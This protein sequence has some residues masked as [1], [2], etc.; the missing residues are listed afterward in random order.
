MLKVK[1]NK[2]LI[3]SAVGD[4]SLHENWIDGNFDTCLIYY[5]D[6]EPPINS[7][8]SIEDKGPKYHLIK[9]AIEN[10]SFFLEYE[11][12]WLPD[13][14]VL[15]K[16]KDVEKLFTFMD[17]F[18]LQ[19]AQP[20]IVGYYSL[21]ITLCHP[22]NKLRFT[23]YVENMCPCFSS[24]ALKKC[25]MTFDENKS[26]WGYDSLWDKILNYPKRGIA[27]ID[28]IIAT[29]TRP[30][31]GGDL[32]KNNEIDPMSEGIEV[33]NKFQL[34][35]GRTESM[36]YGTPIYGGVYGTVVYHTVT[37]TNEDTTDKSKRIWPPIN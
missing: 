30:V 28:D 35:D 12:I 7:K 19:L 14:D 21:R 27:I 33:F 22:T 32:Y 9:K 8:Y 15:I 16:S 13:D 11:N 23:N 29:H 34:C 24:D 6:K 26:G 20:S 18:Q 3:I 10:N 31:F 37:K 17:D 25:Y 2:N 1:N 4:E 36:K 5:G